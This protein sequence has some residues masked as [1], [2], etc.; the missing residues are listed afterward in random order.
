M[1][2]DGV[3]VRNQARG[4]RRTS[5]RVREI[6]VLK[7]RY[8]GEWG[9]IKRG[10]YDVALGFVVENTES[11]A[12]GGPVVLERRVGKSEARG[13]EVLRLA[14]TPRGPGGDT[15]PFRTVSV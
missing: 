12:N 2:I 10:K 9:G 1:G 11:A 5:G 3:N 4:W 13:K 8:L 14:E 15:R 6:A 7:G